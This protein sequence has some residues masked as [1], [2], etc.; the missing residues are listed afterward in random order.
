MACL[1][2]FLGCKFL[3]DLHFEPWR[4]H[5]LYLSNTPFSG[6]CFLFLPLC[7]RGS[8][9]P[10][11]DSWCPVILNLGHSWWEP[12]SAWETRVPCLLAGFI[13]LREGIWIFTAVFSNSEKEDR[14][15]FGDANG[16]M[17]SRLQL[18]IMFPGTRKELV[19]KEWQWILY[20]QTQLWW[21][22]NSRF[23]L[24]R[25]P[26]FILALFL[27]QMCNISLNNDLS[28]QLPKNFYF[29]FNSTV[30]VRRPSLACNQES[31]DTVTS[32]WF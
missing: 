12:P 24:N 8:F 15:L 5:L 16:T 31:S 4:G 26:S 14:F 32:L 2:G 21:V 7:I 22:L 13:N 1:L 30:L 18:S 25:K 19:Y 17:E 20:K 9:V 11:N 27:G 6:N 29:L 3:K 23:Y 28:L 10:A